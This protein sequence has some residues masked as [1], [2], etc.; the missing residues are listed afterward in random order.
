MPPQTLNSGTTLTTADLASEK[1]CQ[2]PIGEAL[3]QTQTRN[4]NYDVSQID[5]KMTAERDT[6]CAK[7]SLEGYEVY[8]FL[9]DYLQNWDYERV[10]Q[11]SMS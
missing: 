7:T 10:A 3:V 1:Q 11:E 2:Q 9:I 4:G 5:D 6:S 8:L